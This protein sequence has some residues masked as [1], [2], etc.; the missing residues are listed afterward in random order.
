MEGGHAQNGQ[1]RLLAA[2]EIGSVA[3]YRFNPSPQ[4]QVA[5]K[6]SEYGFEASVEGRGW[7][8]LWRVRKH[9]E[10]GTIFSPRFCE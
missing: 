6:V 9:V 2:Y 7:D 1:L 5:T 10:T 8:C 3:L 4:H